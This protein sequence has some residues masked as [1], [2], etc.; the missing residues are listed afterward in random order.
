MSI[1][2]SKKMKPL[3][4]MKILK[5]NVKLKSIGILLLGV[6]LGT[7]I[8]QFVYQYYTT[9]SLNSNT[10]DLSSLKQQLESHDN[11]EA[12]NIEL[13]DSNGQ[14]M[15]YQLDE[16]TGLYPLETL[17]VAEYLDSELIVESLPK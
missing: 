16:E 2:I 7:V 17:G 13:L 8:S 6:V 15:S 14:V 5:D 10:I 3:F 12:A 1:Q 11:I 9:K 4:S